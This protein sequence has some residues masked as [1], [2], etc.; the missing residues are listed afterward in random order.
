MTTTMEI[1]GREVAEI[2]LAI[3]EATE[4]EIERITDP[5]ITV[6]AGAKAREGAPKEV[7]RHTMGALHQRK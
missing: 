7:H 1:D 5:L 6:E 3:T 4:T 2:T